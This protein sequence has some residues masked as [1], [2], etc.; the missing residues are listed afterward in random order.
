MKNEQNITIEQIS[1]NYRPEIW[2][3]CDLIT[4]LLNQ[5]TGLYAYRMQEL[6]S[7]EINNILKDKDVL[8]KNPLEYIVSPMKEV[9]LDYEYQEFETDSENKVM[10][11]TYEK[12][13]TIFD[14]KKKELGDVEFEIF[15]HNL[16]NNAES[17][18]IRH[19]HNF[20]MRFTAWRNAV[21]SH[22]TIRNG[23][24]LKC[25]LDADIK[26]LDELVDYDAVLIYNLSEINPQ[27]IS[28][29]KFQK[30]P[31]IEKLIN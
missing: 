13:P 2:D 26:S 15:L 3:S 17:K 11:M 4:N 27:F 10:L 20:S 30:K 22:I 21:G 31:D 14:K 7:S 9:K 28:F 24:L 19:L 29:V 8:I 6:L 18:K 12:N 5:E 16:K 25:L 1:Q 23:F